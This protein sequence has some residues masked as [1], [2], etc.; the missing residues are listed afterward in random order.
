MALQVWLPLNGDLYNQGLSKVITVNNGATVNNNGKIGKCYSF[1]GSSYIDTGYTESFG[2]GDFTICCWI[3]LT[4]TSG[5]TYQCII[6]NKGTGAASVGVSLYYNQNQKK[7]LWSTADGSNATEIWSVDTF[8]TVIFNQWHH[9]AMVRNNSDVKKGYFYFDGVRKEI[10]SVPAIRNITSTVSLKV[11]SV[12][13]V[14]A[15][16]YYTGQINDVRIYNHALNDKEIEEI[17]KGLVLHYQLNQNINILNNCYNYPIFDT[18]SSSGGWNHWGPSG[19][20]GTFSQNTDKKY[21]YNKLNM[22][23]HCVDNT[24]SVSG[25]YY[26]C[27]Q[28]PAFE[29]GY[30][31]LQFIVKEAN[32]LPITETICVPGWNARNGG[33]PSNKWT[34]VIPL[35]D[36]FY[37]CQVDGLSQDGS[38]NLVSITVQPGYKIYVS[39]GYCENDRKI[40]SN[41]FIQDHLNIIYDSSGY[42]HNGEVINTASVEIPSPKNE[43]S[44]HMSATNQKVKITG[45]TTIGFN[46]SYSFS[47]WEKISSADPMHWGFADGVRLNGM[48]TGHLW[49]TGDGSSN[50][51]YKPGTTTQVSNPSVNIWHHWVMTGDGSKCRVYQDGVLWG[52]AKTYKTIS[53]TTIYINGWDA[54]TSYCSNN[55]SMSDFRIYA[56]AL[57]PAQIKEL[58]ETSKIVDGT[59]VKARD[60]EVS[61]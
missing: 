24:A 15:A 25:K 52:E 41:L 22:Y 32:G 16:Y 20:S 55:A 27:Y 10:A 40:C 30:R 31:S 47:W 35:G 38:N 42:N 11:G 45:L 14:Y 37:L 5:K 48:Y 58:Y 18:S 39:E 46:N 61:T 28:S 17:S 51:L 53:G 36:N 4:Q 54:G 50:P 34:R 43:L 60:L 2:T 57:T 21:I 59:T 23:S 13:P 9:I 29:G 44:F 49:N 26:L 7:F 8:D 56:T 33:A 1:N 6:G 12:T 19:H 3:Y